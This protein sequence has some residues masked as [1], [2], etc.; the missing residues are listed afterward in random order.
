MRTIATDV[1]RV[2]QS[3]TRLRCANTSDERIEV[4]LGVEILEDLR[5]IVL[6]GNPG[7]DFLHG[8]DAAFAKFLRL[9]VPAVASAP[10]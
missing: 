8:F 2:C 7:P 9:L 6:D 1:P 4:L 3:V 5:N 10:Q